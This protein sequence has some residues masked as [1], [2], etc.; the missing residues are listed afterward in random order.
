MS[1]LKMLFRI[2]CFLAVVSFTMVDSTPVQAQSKKNTKT[3]KKDVSQLPSEILAKAGSEE[4][5]YN[6][7]EEAYKKNM[8]RKDSSLRQVPL[9]SVY[10]FLNMYINYRLKVQDATNR[11]LTKDSS[12]LAD[13]RENRAA[14]APAYLLEKKLTEPNVEQLLKRRQ[15]ELK[16]AVI[17]IASQQGNGMDTSASYRKAAATLKKIK[18]GADFAKT[19]RDSSDDEQSRVNGGEIPYITGGMILREVED[20]A[21]SLKPGQVFPQPIRTKYGYFIVKL[22]KD[23]SRQRVR[24]S[25]I[26]IGTTVERDSAA[27]YHVADSLLQLLRK[28]ANFAT[29]AKNSSEDKTSAAHGGDL[30]SFYTRSLG[31]ESNPGKLLPEF[32]DALFALRDGEISPIIKTSYGFHIIKRDSTRNLSADDERETLKKLYKRQYFERDKEKFIDSLRTAYGYTWNEATLR[33]VISSLDST[34]STLDAEWAGKIAPKLREEA[35]YSTKTEKLTVQNFIDSVQKRPDMRGVPLTHDGF[36]RAL[37]R[38]TEPKVLAR[39]TENLEQQ[40]ADFAALMKEYRDAL[41]AFRVEDQEVWSK[42]KFDS[43]QARVYFDTLKVRFMTDTRY[44][45]TEIF[46]ASDTLAQSVYN[47][48]TRVF[49]PDGTFF[50]ELAAKHT[51]RKGMR[52]KNGVIGWVT[53]KDS[54]LAAAVAEK[55]PK[56]KDVLAPIKI[57]NGYAVLR[58]NEIEYPR[59]KTFEEALPEFAVGFQDLTQKQLT[60]QW[61]ERLRSKYPVVIKHDTI[62]SIWS[63]GG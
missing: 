44:N 50:E 13:I 57:D 26:L 43:V 40:Y 1:S 5:T 59:Q 51:Q 31:F 7:L 55:N 25:H 41:L 23:D 30:T 9:D 48:A 36:E 4:I 56:P 10:D 29:L 21:F 63:H 54:K 3:G 58:V 19:A 62:N 45:L 11:G 34:K 6:Q 15:R 39:A 24:G 12:V 49:H 2:L 47:E 61:V 16:V 32:E 14:L 60:Q 37:D 18:D 53:V 17:L 28:G 46:L 8:I 27:A 20:A 38:M 33:Q 52:E 42:L 22:I 35:L